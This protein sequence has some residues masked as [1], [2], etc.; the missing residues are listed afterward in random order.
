MKR[1][2]WLTLSIISLAMLVVLTGCCSGSKP[3]PQGT[4]PPATQES[5][6]MKRPFMFKEAKLP[7]GF[8]PPGPVDEVVYK[9]YPPYRA[10]MVKSKE[11]AAAGQDSMFRSLFKHIQRNDIPMTAPVEMEYEAG[12]AD[13]EPVS[14]AFLYR[15]P[16]VGKTGIDQDVA[17]VDL[18]AM[19]VLSVGVRGRYSASTYQKGLKKL[20]DY[21]TANPGRYDVAGPPRVLGYNSP[22]I[23][24]FL[25]YSEIQ[26][27]V[28]P[29]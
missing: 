4:P 12:A 8:P 25:R 7:E 1:K 27:P 10:A 5:A 9:E 19:T 18:P 24:W 28:K 23:I 29:R 15:T 21:L 2:R 13:P 14:M 11:L 17:V 3:G 6:D 20:Q 16:T 22:F 26:L